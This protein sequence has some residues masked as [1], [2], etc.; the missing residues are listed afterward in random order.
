MEVESVF[1]RKPIKKKN[2]TWCAVD[3]YNYIC[4]ICARGF[5]DSNLDLAVIDKLSFFH[6]IDRNS[7]YYPYTVN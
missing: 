3:N 6:K 5:L 4:D 7:I 1:N 2:K